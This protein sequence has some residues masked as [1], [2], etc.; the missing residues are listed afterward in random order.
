MVVVPHLC[1]CDHM[2]SG[3]PQRRHAVVVEVVV[4]R[5]ARHAPP[6][7]RSGQVVQ[8]LESPVQPHEQHGPAHQRGELAEATAHR[9]LGVG[10]LGV[11]LHTHHTVKAR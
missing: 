11:D 7:V 5:R 3:R 2:I 8:H 10:P 6:E 4:V 9:G 1:L